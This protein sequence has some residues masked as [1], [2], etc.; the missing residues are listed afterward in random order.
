MAV[1][2]VQSSGHERR[3]LRQFLVK[4]H[5][6]RSRRNAGAMLPNIQV[7]QNFDAR[8]RV[9]RGGAQRPQSTR[10]INERGKFCLG[11]FFP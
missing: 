2:G 3:G 7:K 4:R 10:F 5:R 1:V 8:S 6:R 9:R 11:K